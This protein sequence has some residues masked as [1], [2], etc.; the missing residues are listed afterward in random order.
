MDNV[1]FVDI[2]VQKQSLGHQFDRSKIRT[3]QSTFESVYSHFT[4]WRISR[5]KKKLEK[6]REGLLKDQFNALEENVISRQG[7]GK[8]NRRTR[9]IARL[10]EKIM[11][12]S[13]ENVPVNFRAS[14]AIKL[15]DKMFASCELNANGAYAAGMD[16]YGEVFEN[17]SIADSVPREDSDVAFA[18]TEFVPVVNGEQGLSEEQV[19]SRVAPTTEMNDISP[20]VDTQPVE[21][22]SLVVDVPSVDT[23]AE[24]GS[25]QKMP[26]EM[27]KTAID[28]QLGQVVPTEMGAIPPIV[29][30]QPVEDS[31]LVV[32]VPS[33]D[34]S[35]EIGSEQ[36][37]PEEMV[38]T[39]IDGQLGQVVP[40]EMG[41]IPPIVDTQP[42]EDSSLVVDVPAG[43]SEVGDSLVQS[44]PIDEALA[45]EA[46][47]EVV[48]ESVDDSKSVISVSPTAAV[49]EEENP[50]IQ[51]KIDDVFKK[52]DAALGTDSQVV[53][54]D[55]PLDTVL[56]K[57]S[58][59]VDT[60]DSVDSIDNSSDSSVAAGVVSDEWSSLA[61]DEIKKFQ[62]DLEAHPI[63]S[64]LTEEQ[65]D[66]DF[67]KYRP[68]FGLNDSLPRENIVVVPERS[69]DS[70]LFDLT[71]VDQESALSST[72]ADKSS[73]QDL[74]FDYSDAT[75]GDI[76]K[77]LGDKSSLEDFK[78]ARIRV[79]ELKRRQKETADAKA[80][81]EKEAEEAAARAEEARRLAE[82]RQAIVNERMA[83]LLDYEGALKE[84]CEF[85][86]SRTAAAHEA[87]EASMRI[88]EEQEAEARGADDLIAEID[89]VIA[90]EAVNVVAKGK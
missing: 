39:A 59:A 10:E 85:N 66:N 52:V 36:K 27:V 22:S 54:A 53:S 50:N 2:D 11:I 80:R 6:K 7:M 35:A 84:D 13:K 60:T 30:T 43:T 34:T 56:E 5:L 26:E 82:E 20:I 3:K 24:I 28:G 81:A 88:I 75:L 61:D 83:K 47:S 67:E 41:A 71:A 64:S 19:D 38:K 72:E 23:S 68:N 8:L 40:T 33:V 31:S 15:R 49:V 87:V 77:N 12:L 9:V 57:D 58:Q 90:P 46:S 79:E 48:S 37:M 14:R 62:D 18:A 32:D 55:L 4:N 65:I 69:D 63:K 21:D 78:A 29:D 44:T 45:S 86:E 76:A 70:P 73:S 42:V 89:S 25:E 1:N 16:K 51:A 17:A 74:H